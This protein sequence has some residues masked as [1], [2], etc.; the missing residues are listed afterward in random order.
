MLRQATSTA[1]T[2]PVAAFRKGT[3]SSNQPKIMCCNYHWFLGL[4]QYI[5]DPFKWQKVAM[6][7]MQMNNISR[8]YFLNNSRSAFSNRRKAIKSD[9]SMRQHIAH[10]LR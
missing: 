3:S 9:Y 10:N 7:N 6:N 1:L 4:Y 8:I 2:P 5:Y